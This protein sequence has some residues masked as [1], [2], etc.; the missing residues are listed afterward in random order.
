MFCELKGDISKI[1]KD[2][3]SV[4]VNGV[5]YLVQIAENLLDSLELHSKTNLIIE[6]KFKVDKIVLFGFF[7]EFQQF[8]FNAIGNISGVT[9]RVALNISGYFTP[10]ELIH[11]INNPEENKNFKI[12]GMGAKTW[13]KIVFS[14]QRNKNFIKECS[15]FTNEKNNQ[16]QQNSIFNKNIVENEAFSALINIGINKNMANELIL[17]ASKNL[18]KTTS[19]TEELVRLALSYYSN[20]VS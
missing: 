10:S 18:E 2:S 1:F 13:E 15:V 19:T 4:S 9:D 8:C 3:I 7:N 16:A 14:L 12:N 6:T 5:G 17:K 11:L 20:S